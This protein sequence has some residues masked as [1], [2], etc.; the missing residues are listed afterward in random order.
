MSASRNDEEQ[1]LWQ[2]TIDVL[3]AQGACLA[4]AIKVADLMVRAEQRR[5]REEA[6]EGGPLSRTRYRTP[7][8]S[9]PVPLA[10]AGW[11]SS[12]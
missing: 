9:E 8:S 4:T 12:G 2:C 3:V 5:L 6:A 7:P 1:A 10:R 11:R